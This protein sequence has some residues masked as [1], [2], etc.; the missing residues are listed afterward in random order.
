MSEFANISE[1]TDQHKFQP[2]DYVVYTNDFGVCWGVKVI[3]HCALMPTTRDDEGPQAPHYHYEGSDTPWYPV[4][5]K[6]LTAATQED[7][8]RHHMR[9]DDYFQQKYGFAPTIE[10]LAGC[11]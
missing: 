7:L 3:L 10:Q 2:G 5:E 9:D 1:K 6:N 11:Y 4:D 8:K